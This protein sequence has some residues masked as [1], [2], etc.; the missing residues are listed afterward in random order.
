MVELIVVAL[1]A[2]RLCPV[3]ISLGAKC[4]A[5]LQKNSDLTNQFSIYF[6]FIVVAWRLNEYAVELA[7]LHEEAVVAEFGFNLV[8]FGAGYHGG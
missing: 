4:T 8:I 6:Q 7:V 3:F 2:E 5:K 1:G